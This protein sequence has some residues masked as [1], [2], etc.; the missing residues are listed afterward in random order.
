MTHLESD[1][2][3]EEIELDLLL[4]GIQRRYGYD[5]RD[6]ARASLRRRV[7]KTVA[8]EGLRS[9]SALQE[10]VL[11]DRGCFE[12]LVRNVSINV[13]SMFRDPGMYL[14]FRQAVVPRLR[15]YP[16]LR[17]WHAGCATGEEVHSLAILL[18]EEGLLERTQ[19]HATDM[20]DAMIR[21][22]REGKFPLESVR[23]YAANYAKAGG[24]ADFA[25]YY[26]PRHD[27]AVFHDFLRSNVLFSQHVLGGDGPFHH[28]DV[29]VCR[30]VAI[31]FNPELQA[32]V[33]DL[34][35]QSLVP[36]GV[37]VL[38]LKERIDFA[39]RAG[40]FDAIDETLRIYRRAS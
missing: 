7:R 38:G 4:Q 23:E 17:V 20:S 15:T 6:Y 29:I 22:A 13:T 32:R 36:L 24:R 28:F 10:R 37:L 40:R 31:Y 12:R 1:A 35:Y 33:H 9:V 30:N 2:E 3:S 21:T 5:F 27:Q 14:R 8:E 16:S 26:T 25:S 18:H 39:P 34:L 11:R 19:V